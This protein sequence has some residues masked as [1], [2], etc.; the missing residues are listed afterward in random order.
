MNECGI[1]IV[2]VR[3]FEKMLAGSGDAPIRSIFTE[4]ELATCRAKPRPA[5]SLAARFAVK[6]SVLKM[7]PK[8]TALKDLDFI[9]VEVATDDYGAPRLK[10]GVRLTRC[11]KAHK[12]SGIAVSMSHAGSFACGLAVAR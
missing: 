1:D 9:D 8:E 7:F 2:D 12:M 10:M 4:A 11:M 3:R 5:E 6:E